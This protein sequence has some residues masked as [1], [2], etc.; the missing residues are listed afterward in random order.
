MFVLLSI[1]S[2]CYHS[3]TVM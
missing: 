1:E 3:I 2:I